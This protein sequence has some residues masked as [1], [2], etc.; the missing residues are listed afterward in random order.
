M[1]VRELID[2]R[3]VFG[4]SVIDLPPGGSACERAREFPE[5]QEDL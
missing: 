1:S 4:D 3:A 2:G 5:P